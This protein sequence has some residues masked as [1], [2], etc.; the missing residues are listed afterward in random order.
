MELHAIQISKL[1][2]HHN[3]NHHHMVIKAMAAEGGDNMSRVVLLQL[4]QI[5][6]LISRAIHS[7][8]QI[9]PSIGHPTIHP[10]VIIRLLRLILRLPI[11]RLMLPPTLLI[12]A[13]NINGEHFLLEQWFHSSHNLNKTPVGI[14]INTQM[15][16]TTQCC[17]GDLPP[18]ATLGL[19]LLQQVVNTGQEMLELDVE[20]LTVV[21]EIH[22]IIHALQTVAKQQLFWRA[23]MRFLMRINIECEKCKWM[24]MC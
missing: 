16:S 18:V 10:L 14:R 5:L 15:C 9:H 8:T 11:I 12:T 23:E 4:L 13:I 7:H 24:T 22:Q 3:I 17:Q 6:A 19:G 2:H 20:A 1:L 21:K